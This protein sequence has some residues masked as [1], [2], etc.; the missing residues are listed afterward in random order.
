M[1]NEGRGNNSPAAF[2]FLIPYPSSL[3]PSKMWCGVAQGLPSI[4]ECLGV[5]VFVENGKQCE[6]NIFLRQLRALQ[7]FYDAVPYLFQITECFLS[8][9]KRKV[10]ANV[11]GNGSGIVKGVSIRPQ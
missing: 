5:H 4:G 3:I 11:M 2:F 10:P 7:F 9:Q 8:A 6:I 1:R